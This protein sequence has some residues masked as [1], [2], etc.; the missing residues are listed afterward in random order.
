MEEEMIRVYHS[1]KKFRLDVVFPYDEKKVT[2]M[3]MIVGARFEPTERIWQISNKQ[4]PVLIALNKTFNY[5][6]EIVTNE[7]KNVSMTFEDIE[8]NT[9][10]QPPRPIGRIFIGDDIQSDGYEIVYPQIDEKTKYKWD[11]VPDE[12]CTRKVM[13][14]ANKFLLSDRNI[15]IDGEKAVSGLYEWC[16]Y[17][18]HPIAECSKSS[19]TQLF[20]RQ[21]VIKNKVVGY[22]GWQNIHIMTEYFRMTGSKLDTLME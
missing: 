7:L 22:S 21:V 13:L 10:G 3:K 11:M 5:N 15:K 2:L 9:F 4:I 14:V 16:K 8:K 17:I 12:P 20:K 18:N 19:F 1:K 6:F